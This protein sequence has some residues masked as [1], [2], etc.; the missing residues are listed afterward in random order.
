[1]KKPDRLIGYLEYEKTYFPF[2]FDQETF[3]LL[4]FPPSIEEWNRTSSPRNMMLDFSCDYKKHEW[5]KKTK[6][7]G[8]HRKR[9]ELFLR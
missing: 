6:Y 5:L 1:M 9:T 8:T 2:E 7:Q 3:T 4:L